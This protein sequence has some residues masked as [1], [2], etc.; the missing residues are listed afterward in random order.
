[1]QTKLPKNALRNGAIAG[2]IIA[3]VVLAVT[4]S[5]RFA[6][7][8]LAHDATESKPK[9]YPFEHIQIAQVQSPNINGDCNIV[10]SGNSIQGGINCPKVQP[11][12]PKIEFGQQTVTRRN[13]GTYEMTV[14][15][16]LSSQVP[17]SLMYVSVEGSD[18]LDF[19]IEPGMG[20]AFSYWY[21][22]M[23]DNGAK[24]LGFTNPQIGAYVLKIHTAVPPSP[25]SFR[26]RWDAK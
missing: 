17:V 3:A 20:G 9:D 22:K 1:M 6:L 7:P 15:A 23:D 21:G 26:V 24:A 11:N 16:N 10:G 18:V 8:S 13:D 14:A 5:L 4:A 12:P 2:S 19:N 25:N